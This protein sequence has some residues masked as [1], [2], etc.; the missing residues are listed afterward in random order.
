[1]IKV[2][3]NGYGRIGQNVVRILMD[4][5]DNGLELVCINGMADMDSTWRKLMF[6]SVYGRFKGTAEIDGNHLVI[7]GKKVL[8]TNERDTDKLP[9][10]DLGV[11]ILIDSTGKYLTADL[12]KEHL[13]AGAKK[14][15]LTAPGKGGEDVTVVM[16]VNEGEYDPAK[17]NIVSN[18]SCT[19][20]CL[21]P[22]SK[23][24]DAEFGIEHGMMTTIHAYTNGQNITDGKSKDPRRARAGAIN[25][26]PTTTGAAKAVGLVLPQLQ[27]KM[28]G[29]AIRVPVPT[30]SL[31]DLVATTR[32][33]VTV[34]A[35]NAAFKKAAE[36]EMKGILGYNELPLVSTDY[37]AESNSSV[38][39]G[40]ST[41]VLGDN[42]VKVYSW[43]D[44][45]YGYSLRVVDLAEYMVEK[46]L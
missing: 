33:K 23:V 42:L 20:N 16:G 4:R 44:N 30:V 2:A 26:I 21:A 36:G 1:M 46:G 3:V 24:L 37:I 14:V 13:E 43:Y 22:L 18:A 8:I 34:E 15:I 7:N 19:T 32:E 17:H 45:E 27:G 28:T 40:L 10:K 11:D 6:D 31:V 5:P 39:D 9:W 12:A 29:H 41:L 25:M 35:V 38:I